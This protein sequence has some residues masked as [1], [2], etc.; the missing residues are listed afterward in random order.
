MVESPFAFAENPD[1]FFK[2]CADYLLLTRCFPNY[3]LQDKP[4]KKP[5]YPNIVQ[6]LSPLTR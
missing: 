1:D 4:I 3:L 2:T 6:N 5:N